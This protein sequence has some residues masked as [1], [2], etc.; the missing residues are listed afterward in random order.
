[1]TLVSTL[2]TPADSPLWHVL[3]AVAFAIAFLLQVAGFLSAAHAIMAARTAQGSIA[4]AICLVTMPWFA[5]PAYWAFGR[6]KF[7]GYVKARRSGDT[8]LHQVARDA[9]RCASERQLFVRDTDQ[10]TR[11][12]ERLVQM[13]FTRLNRVQLLV[14]G[15]QT[16]AAIFAG[17]E[18]AKDYILSQF[19]IVHDDQLGRELKSRLL[20]K[21]ADGVRIYFLY[22][23]V[24]CHKLPS[25]Y[26][27]EL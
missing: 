8:K 11:A 3:L 5:L 27:Q 18:S 21:A 26:V 13:P 9:A 15:E 7:T 16:F 1:M 4:W 12:L 14:D 22:D 2:G 24:G 10:R 19:F 17:I 23:D 20:A 6:S 25:H